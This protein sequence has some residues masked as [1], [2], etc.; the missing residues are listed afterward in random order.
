MKEAF[1]GL[2]TREWTIL[3][4]NVWND[5]SSPR[6]KHHLEH[7]A[8][9]PVKLADRLIRIYSAPG[10]LVFDPFVGVGSTLIAAFRAG[11]PSV[12]IE[13]NPRFVQ[14]TEEWVG[15]ERGLLRKRSLSL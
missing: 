11:R 15:R 13:L 12:G 1:N 8:V 7:G 4:R 9:F 5:V 14:L 2:T 3:S 6:D 10:D